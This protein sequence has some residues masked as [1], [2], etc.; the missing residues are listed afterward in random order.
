M[1]SREM[2]DLLLDVI[3]GIRRVDSETNQDNVRVGVGQRSESTKS[4]SLG[5]PGAR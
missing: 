3:E 5:A 4:V 1:N 2:T